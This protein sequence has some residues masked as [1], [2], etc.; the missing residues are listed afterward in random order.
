MYPDFGVDS[1]WVSSLERG[2]NRVRR[3]PPM[4]FV[5]PNCES[6]NSLL[7]SKKILQQPRQ[8]PSFECWF[9][10]THNFPDGDFP[11]I[12]CL[13][14][15][16]FFQS[17]Q[18]GYLKELSCYLTNQLKLILCASINWSSIEPTFTYVRMLR[19][20]IYALMHTI[21]FPAHTLIHSK[22]NWV[23]GPI[24]YAIWIQKIFDKIHCVQYDW[25]DVD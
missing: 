16:H 15:L 12:A 22:S 9:L 23:S 4:V 8:S 20:L 1:Y 2:W 5:N 11:L 13:P 25:K 18:S 19:H 3:V 24:F 7:F 6:R 21:E 17:F 10:P 14:C